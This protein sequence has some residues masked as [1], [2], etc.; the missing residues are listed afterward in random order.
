M[1]TDI[2]FANSV[3]SMWH[4]KYMISQ[5][6][7][8]NMINAATLGEALAILSE[9]D[10]D[11][12]VVSNAVNESLIIEK[13]RSR[14]FVRFSELCNDSSLLH[15]V[16]AKYNYHNAK[17][18]HWHQASKTPINKEALYPFA[19][20]KIEMD[21]LPKPLEIA[22]SKITDTSTPTEIDNLIEIAYYK[23][24]ATGSKKIKSKNIREY[25]Q[26]MIDLMNIRTAYKCREEQQPLDDL[27]L[28]GGEL[29]K[30][31]ITSIITADIKDLTKEL[32]NFKYRHVIDALVLT[33]Q[34]HNYTLLDTA[35]DEHLLSALE[36]SKNNTFALDPLF[37]WYIMKQEELKIVKTILMGKRLN[38]DSSE[39]TKNLRGF[40][41]RFK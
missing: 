40:N 27:F 39:I 36:A 21:K 19:M 12:P 33:I 14:T 4:H 3:V 24:L 15:C 26:S 5:L 9:C 2:L 35:C 16:S 30:K 8:K 25:F 32:N 34:K 7:I 20:Q 1:K 22:L 29:S 10:Y 41:G 6:H 17:V 38:M 23:D 11:C 13:E 31:E 37:Y 18:L 28:I